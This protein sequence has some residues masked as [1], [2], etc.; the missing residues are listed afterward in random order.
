MERLHRAGARWGWT[1]DIVAVVPEV[2][3]TEHVGSRGSIEEELRRRREP[4]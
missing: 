2:E 4:T 1:P 3:G